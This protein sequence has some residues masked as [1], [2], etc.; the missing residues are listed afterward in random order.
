MLF[1]G[2]TGITLASALLIKKALGKD[3]SRVGKK[4]DFFPAPVFHR[5]DLRLI[6]F[7]SLLPDILDKPL[8]MVFLRETIGNGR[9]FGHTLIFLA[10]I[11][12]AGVLLNRRSRK[13]WLL[14]LAFGTATHLIFDQMWRNPHTLFWP[15][16]GLAFEKKDLSQWLDVTVNS[17]FTNPADYIPELVGASILVWF[18]AGL[19]HRG[20]LL[21]FLK[22]GHT[23]KSY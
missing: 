7:G 22:T 13:T 17:L 15:V 8:G 21:A 9:I 19:I 12:L 23:G 6:L 18:F 20:R 10:G 4:I 14:A 1:F 3:V 5:L 16:L 2:H 11:S